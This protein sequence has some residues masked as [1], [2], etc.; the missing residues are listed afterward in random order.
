VRIT[1]DA[2]MRLKRFI[3]LAHCCRD[4]QNL[5]GMYAVYVGLNQWAMQ[6]LNGLWENLST[7][8]EKRASFF[9]L[10]SSFCHT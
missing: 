9:F 1:D 8:W 7:I 2:Q 3:E 5:H 10:F 6:R 4:V